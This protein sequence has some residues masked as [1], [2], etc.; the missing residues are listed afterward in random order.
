TSFS[1][2]QAKELGRINGGKGSS[3]SSSSS[4]G[5]S[6]PT[7]VTIGGV[8]GDKNGVTFPFGENAGVTIGLDKDKNPS[9]VYKKSK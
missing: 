9:V 7:S 8:T 1:E 6:I 3:S 5:S 2:V 4:G